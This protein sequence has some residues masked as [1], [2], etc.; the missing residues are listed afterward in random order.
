MLC[1]NIQGNVYYS[2]SMHVMY[3]VSQR[4]FFVCLIVNAY[5]GLSC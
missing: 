2:Q 5:A 4:Y 1:H 3:L